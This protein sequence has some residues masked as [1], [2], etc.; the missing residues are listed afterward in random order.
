MKTQLNKY[1]V[2]FAYTKSPLN[3]LDEDFD[4]EVVLFECAPDN[5]SFAV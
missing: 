5:G 2:R 4:N 1:E 3:L